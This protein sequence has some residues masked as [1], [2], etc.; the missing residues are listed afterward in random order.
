MWKAI[1]AAIIAGIRAYFGK[2]KPDS[3][4]AEAQKEVTEI[5]NEA[6]EREKPAPAID[7]A[8]DKLRSK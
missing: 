4:I 6:L 1:F 5:R 7:D 2:N 3:Q 8:I